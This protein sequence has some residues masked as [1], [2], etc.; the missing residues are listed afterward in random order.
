MVPSSPG[1]PSCPCRISA[2]S[3]AHLP[4]PGNAVRIPN[5]PRCGFSPLR[6]KQGLRALPRLPFPCRPTSRPDAKSR[7]GSKGGCRPLAPIS[8]APAPIKRHA[9]KAVY[10]GL[11]P[12]RVS[13]DMCVFCSLAVRSVN[14]LSKAHRAER[15]A[16]ESC[17]LSPDTVPCKHVFP[18]LCIA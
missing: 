16:R 11:A 4:S 8:A 10:E 3:S 2:T 7:I 14:P 18:H 6:C 12:L 5:A 15:R 13:F 1:F 9:A 17:R